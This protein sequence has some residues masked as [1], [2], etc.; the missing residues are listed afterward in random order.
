M[1]RALGE[2]WLPATVGIVGML[3]SFTVWGLLV[4]ER[5]QHLLDATADMAAESR[6]SIELGLERQLHELGGLATLWGEFGLPPEPQWVMDVRQR[7]ARTP[8]MIALAWVDPGEPEP[9]IVTADATPQAAVAHLVEPV[10]GLGAGPRG[11]GPERLASG[12]LA[13]RVVLPVRPTGPAGASG[14]LVGVF[15]VAP[16]VEHVLRG[17]APG[18]AIAIDWDGEAVFARGEPSRD[19]WQA[20]WRADVD[21][22]LPL[23]G[24]WRM[25]WR[26]TPA[27]AAARLT[28]IR[29]YLLA[30]GVLLS[31]VMAVASHQLRVI[32]RQ[33]R[34]LESANQALERRGG[35]LESEVAARTAELSEVVDELEAFNH[36]VSHDLRTPLGAILNFV[37]ILEE[38]HRDRPLDAEGLVCLARIRRSATRATDLLEDLLQLSRAGRA[39]LRFERVDMT[40][41]AR[42]SFA[43]VRAAEDDF[44]VE[45]LLDP[46][47]E[48]H[49]DRTLLGDVFANL[50][51]NALKYSRGKEKRRIGVR[52][53]VEG[54][55]CVYVVVDNGIGFD[56]RFAEKLFGLFERLHHDDE[57]EGTGVGL[58]MV[59]RIVRRHGGR[60]W[61][62]GRPGEGASFAFSL[63]RA[64]S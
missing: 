14:T 8:G 25:A 6:E 49:G 5:R 13:S 30:A 21:V 41:L 45:F 40:A 42:E 7:V 59:A 44:D 64:R 3:V 50:L 27:H 43:Q 39:A 60:A 36:S 63:P 26:P 12:A 18:F 22:A 11:L 16:F 51:G 61:A 53:R 9:R 33:S 10:R 62:E 17:K 29:H 47:P 4:G 57:F 38:D 58:A 1:R 15:E 35:E 20:W 37:A 31:I 56:M 28:P 55:A 2:F 24:A 19:P 34:G 52:G 32:T 46:L 23:G 54:D 48:A